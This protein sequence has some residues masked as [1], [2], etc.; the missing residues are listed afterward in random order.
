M[1]DIA[2]IKDRVLQVIIR[3]LELNISTEDL[4]KADRLDELFGMDSIAIIEL[5][6][7]IEQEFE[8]KVPP[9]YLTVTIFQNVNTI[10]EHVLALIRGKENGS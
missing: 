5:V 8:I 3:N 10:A 1:S 7:G 9:E 2:N 6:V 4:Q